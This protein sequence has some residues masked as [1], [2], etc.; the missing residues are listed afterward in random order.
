[1]SVE[2]DIEELQAETRATVEVL[3]NLFF[4]SLQNAKDPKKFLHDFRTVS[5]DDCKNRSKIATD[6]L[7]QGKDDIYNQL[8]SINDA[9]ERISKEIADG[10]SIES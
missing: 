10:I 7:L 4:V 1:M 8:D 6:I 9:V 2:T 3:R 5:E